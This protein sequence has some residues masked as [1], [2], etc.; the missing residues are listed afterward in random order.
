MHIV[1]WDTRKRDVTKD[2]GGGYGM[3]KY[4]GLGGVRGKIIRHLS[5]RDR[6]PVALLFAYLASSFR[7]LGHTVEYHEDTV[8]VGADLYVFYPSIFTIDLER[9]AMKRVLAENPQARILVTG[10][11]GHTMPEAFA[12]LD[13]TIVRGEA[14]QLYWKLDEVLAAIG[15]TVEVGSVEDLDALPLPDWSLFQPS[16]FRI[17]YDF[18]RFP[19]AFIQQSR[20]CTFTCN[21]CPYIVI[22]NRTRFRSPEGIVEEIRR[23]MREHGF[24]SF[25]F[26]D[27]LFG[28]N[29]RRVMELAELLGRLPRKIQFSIESRIEFLRRETLV[30]LRDVGLTSV[31]VGIETPDDQTLRQYRRKPIPEDHQ[32]QFVAACRELGIRSVAGF[33]V[34]F[35]EDTAASIR[36][37]LQYAKKLNPTYANF[38]I[39]TPYPGTPFYRENQDQISDVSF[40][41][42]DMYTPVMKYEHLTHEEVSALH[43]KCFT[44][45]YFRWP[46]LLENMHLL[47]PTLRKLGV[48]RRY[49]TVIEDTPALPVEQPAATSCHSLPT[50]SLD[51]VKQSGAEMNSSDEQQQS[52]DRAC[53]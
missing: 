49:R 2:M 50:I 26:R 14:E 6:R 10:V 37:V 25:K 40:T 33:M 9:E 36:S 52:S 44:Q 11:V 35:P 4:H 38:N 39:V 46:Y 41:K 7:Q 30:A 17:G 22:E 16:R 31:T 15:P 3:G 21:Y 18:T 27:P 20:G 34:G 32:H 53:A 47:W 23:G 8:P 24:R 29:R 13:V 19:T 12:D 43:A 5:L 1:L 45:Y 42:Y 51:A 28:L 48:G